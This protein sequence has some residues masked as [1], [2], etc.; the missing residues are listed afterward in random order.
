MKPASV[1]PDD[2]AAA[3]KLIQVSHETVV[4]LDAFVELLLKWQKAVQLIAPSSIPNI[5]TRHIADSLQLL[6]HLPKETKTI[7]D[8]GSGGGFPGLI[9][10]IGLR[11]QSGAT[12][13]LVESDSRKAAFLQEAIRVLKLPAKVHALRIESAT[14]QIGAVDVV[15]ARAL[16]PL[17]RLLE[18]AEPLLKS[19]AKAIFLKGQD[20][21]RE[22]TEAAKSWNIRAKS[23]TSKT[24]PQGKIL[25]VEAL[26]KAAP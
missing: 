23:V 22:L 13:H 26:T 11:D 15:T 5:W 6:D 14:K 17:P 1:N 21:D 4:A 10:A 25:L 19:G 24:D 20:V 8:L 9:L 12:I 18:L 2:R 3:L 16:A 7:A